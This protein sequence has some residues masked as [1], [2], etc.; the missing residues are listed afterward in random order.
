MLISVA[1]GAAVAVV[2]VAAGFWLQLQISKLKP[3]LAPGLMVASLVVRLGLL[4]AVLILLGLYTGLNMLALALTL[5][6]VFTALQTWI[7][8]L[9]VKQAKKNAG[10]TEASRGAEAGSPSAKKSV[11]GA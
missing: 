2:F 5:G 3:V 4:A 9:Q 7:I 10:E 11:K 8:S 6:V 1:V